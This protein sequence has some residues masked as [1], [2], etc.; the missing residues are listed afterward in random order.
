MSSSSSRP[1]SVGGRFTRFCLPPMKTVMKSRR[2]FRFLAFSAADNFRFDLAMRASLGPGRSRLH[3]PAPL[4]RRADERGE[5]R[6]RL[7]R[8]RLELG[9]ELDA[10]EP[11]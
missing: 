11:G 10:D 6:V 1:S 3:Q 4:H 2:A 7:E 5:Q 8:A 9:V